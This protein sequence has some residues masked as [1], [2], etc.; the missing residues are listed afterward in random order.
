MTSALIGMAID[1]FIYQSPNH[2][3]TLILGACVGGSNFVAGTLQENGFIPDI[4]SSYNSDIIN[5]KTVQQRIIEISLSAGSAYAVNALIL[6]NMRPN[7]PIQDII[8]IFGGSSLISEYLTDYM[9][10]QKLSYLA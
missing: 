5:I 10:A 7:L 4:G 6:K 3:N 8:L 9:F 2:K 1:K